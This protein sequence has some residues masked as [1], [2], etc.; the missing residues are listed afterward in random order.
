MILGRSRNADRAAAI[1][2]TS[3]DWPPVEFELLMVSYS[4]RPAGVDGSR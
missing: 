4:T 2:F 3:M 1:R